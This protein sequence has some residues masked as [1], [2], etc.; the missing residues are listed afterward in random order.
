VPF[1]SHPKWTCNGQL[2]FV[3]VFFLSFKIIPIKIWHCVL[4]MPMKDVWIIDD[5]YREI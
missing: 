5:K 2:V 3:N 1:S 4:M